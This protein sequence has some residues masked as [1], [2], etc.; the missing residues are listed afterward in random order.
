MSS[1]DNGPRGGH[2]NFFYQGQSHKAHRVIYELMIGPIPS[3]FHL[4]HTCEEKICVN[5]KHL[6]PLIA[7]EHWVNFSPNH[8]AY[9]NARKTHCHLGHPLIPVRNSHK[10]WCRECQR[11]QVKNYYWRQKLIKST[12]ESHSGPP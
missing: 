7:R 4:H 5:P 9:K 12:Q 6:Q 10:R 8:P 1:I 3:G 2:G 11:Q